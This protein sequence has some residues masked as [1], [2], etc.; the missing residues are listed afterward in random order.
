MD[1]YDFVSIFFSLVLSFRVERCEM[2]MDSEVVEE[3]INL[4]GVRSNFRASDHEI[5][6]IGFDFNANHFTEFQWR[7]YSPRIFR[8]KK[9]RKQTYAHGCLL[10]D[11]Y[12]RCKVCEKWIFTQ[13]QTHALNTFTSD[14]IIH[15]G[16]NPL[17][18]LAKIGH[19][20]MT[21]LLLF[22]LFNRFG[23]GIRMHPIARLHHD[24][25]P[26]L[27][28]LFHLESRYNLNM[29]NDFF[30]SSGRKHTCIF[31]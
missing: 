24:C 31:F 8:E 22:K 16:Y 15:R 23:F 6:E 14:S 29:K 4:L 25:Q 27:K 20:I 17:S 26:N 5:I 1:V 7:L 28:L 12:G 10:L 19:L 13:E 18:K 3:V 9:K 21:L 11:F 30:P 2:D